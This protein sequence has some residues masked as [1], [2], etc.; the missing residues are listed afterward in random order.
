GYSE[1]H[2]TEHSHI[3]KISTVNQIHGDVCVEVDE[4][5]F[6]C[7]TCSMAFPSQR[8]IDYHVIVVHNGYCDVCQGRL[9]NEDEAER[10]NHGK[11]HTGEK[12]QQCEYCLKLFSGKSTYKLHLS[13][14]LKC[15]LC[16]K[17]FPRQNKTLHM[18]YHLK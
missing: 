17:I 4:E 15:L 1:Q 9:D 12:P 6:H 10:L 16:G 14:D 2:I 8:C 11:K 5:T 18:K 13:R 3:P 7:P